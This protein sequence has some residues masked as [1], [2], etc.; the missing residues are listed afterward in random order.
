MNR[1]GP[2][3]LCY[4]ASFCSKIFD[5]RWIAVDTLARVPQILSCQK[6]RQPPTGIM[7]LAIRKSRVIV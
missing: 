5:F 6:L 3:E 4:L 1:N 2:L 7:K